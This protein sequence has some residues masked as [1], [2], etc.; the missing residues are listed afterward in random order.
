MAAGRRIVVGLSSVA[1]VVLAGCG[2]G[3]ST[4]P[5]LGLDSG[6][7]PSGEFSI[8]VATPPG[9]VDPLLANSRSSLLL[10][11][12][13]HEPLVARLE[14]PFESVAQRRGL[15]RAWRANPSSTVW[16]FRLRS[17]VRFQDGSLLDA[18]AVQANVNRWLSSERVAA[19]LPELAYADRP[20]P[21]QV[22]IF[23]TAP[24]V[25]LDEILAAPLFGIVSPEALPADGAAG[26]LVARRGTGSG[27]FELRERS[28]EEVVLAR[29]AGWWGTRYRLGPGVDA[30]R[31]LVVES[32]PQRLRLL[33]SGDLLGADDLGPAE[34]RR[35]ARDPLLA[36]VHGSSRNDE[37][38][39]ALSRSVRGLDSS[40]PQNLS[41]L[42]L[43]RLSG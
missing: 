34:Q 7:R 41:D 6:P 40:D 9:P 18:G 33:R 31:L 35:A 17:R 23:L 36:V 27:P 30:L 28:A 24:V 19:V 1:V 37:T 13:I 11:S 26:P 25:N 4:T 42:W 16:T 14:A 20:L 12:Q 5:Q 2:G 15:A 10:T 3:P 32:A 38:A 43:T 22:R 8:A 21:K 29:Y 39:L